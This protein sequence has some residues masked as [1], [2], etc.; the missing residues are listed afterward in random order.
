MILII[1]AVFPPEPVVAAC[2]SNDLATALSE[3]TEVKV[4]SPKPTRPMGFSFND[5]AEKKLPYEHVVMNS[6]TY[7]GSNIIGRMAES[8]SFGKNAVRFITRNHREINCIYLASWPLL[9]PYIIIKST[10]KHRI[11]LVFHV[12]DIYPESLTNKIWVIGRLLNKVLLPLDK[13]VLKHAS[14][15]IAISGK[16]AN[17]LIATRKI[18]THKIDIIQNWQDENRFN[19]KRRNQLIPSETESCSRILTFMYLGNIGPVAGVDFLVRSFSKSAKED[20]ILVIAGNG[21]MK[22]ICIKIAESAG[23]NNIRFW[24]VPPG[25]VPDIQANADIML[26]PVKKG[27]ALSSIPSKLIAY[28]FSAKPIIA[29]VDENSDTAETI[30]NAGCGWVIPPEN[31]DELNDIIRKVMSL[32]DE[33]LRSKG[34]MGYNYAIEHFAKKNNLQKLKNTILNTAKTKQ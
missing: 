10:R 26:L 21:S 11:P 32:P 12:Q 13:Y 4:L 22:E 1:S 24:D 31:Y 17:E 15:V 33:E 16:M 27:A 19:H 30:K 6:F 23:N 28:M 25:K 7:P 34:F 29:C 14:R 5:T 20:A 18:N 8:Y 2:L 9:A 3:V